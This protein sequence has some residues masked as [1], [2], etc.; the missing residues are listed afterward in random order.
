MKRF[1][2]AG[3]S[4]AALLHTGAAFAQ[5]PAGAPA[6]APVPAAAP[7]AAAVPAPAP[8]PAAAPAQQGGDWTSYNPYSGEESDLKNP[9]RTQEE[10]LSWSQQRSTEVLSYKGDNTEVDNKLKSVQKDF[11]QAGLQQYYAYLTDSKLID[12]VKSQGYSVTTIVNG[13]SIILNSGSVAGSYHWLVELPLMVTFLHTNAD[14]NQDPV[15]GGAFKLT[16]QLGRVPQGQGV[17]GMA[18]ESWKMEAAKAAPA[19]SP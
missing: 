14:G 6:A 16:M 12:M 1:W 11:T 17:D 7:P 13:D 10:I 3:L 4:L 5:T 18:I 15:A 9:N 2:L 19:P 8:A